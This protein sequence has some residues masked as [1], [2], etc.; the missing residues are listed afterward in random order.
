MPPSTADAYMI[1]K[2]GSYDV[3]TIAKIDE[4]IVKLT[5]RITSTDRAR[6]EWIWADIDALL[7]RRSVLTLEAAL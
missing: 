7:E 6:R 2:L 3:P 4:A 5:A 1:G